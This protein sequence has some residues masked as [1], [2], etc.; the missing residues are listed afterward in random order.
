MRDYDGSIEAND[1]AQ[2]L[3]LGSVL[4]FPLGEGKSYLYHGVP[5]HVSGSEMSFISVFPEQPAPILITAP[6][7]FNFSFSYTYSAPI[8]PGSGSV[9]RRERRPLV[10]RHVF[11]RRGALHHPR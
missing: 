9:G 11:P 8:V 5:A 3:V 2:R 7:R 4:D 6:N 1:V 10:Q